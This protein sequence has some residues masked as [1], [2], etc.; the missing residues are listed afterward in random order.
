MERIE[1]ILGP[2]GLIFILLVFARAWVIRGS[3][4]RARPDRSMDMTDVED[5]DAGEGPVTGP[6]EYDSFAEALEGYVLPMRQAQPDWER[7]DGAVGIRGRTAF[8]FSRKGIWFDV[9]GATEFGPL[10]AAR[11]WMEAHPG[12]DP[13][14]AQRGGRMARLRLR[15]EIWGDPASVLITTE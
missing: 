12:D 7:L 6:P 9:N 4:Q 5:F 13:L 8:R 15:K 10:L 14:E 2:L 1:L 3:R 11:D